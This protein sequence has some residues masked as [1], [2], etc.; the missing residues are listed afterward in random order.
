M[1]NLSKII[2]AGAEVAAWAVPEVS[3]AQEQ[4]SNPH[5]GPDIS[6]ELAAE[7]AALKQQ[8]YQEG[9][10]QGRQAGLAQAQA[11]IDAQ[12]QRFVAILDALS[13][14]LD[15][16][17][18]RVEQELLTL[19][20]SIAR[21]IVRREI[22][23][24]PAQVVGVVKEALSIL[25]SG[26]QNIEVHLHPEDARLVSDIMLANVDER[27]WKVIEDPVMG[28]GGC[29]VDTDSSTVDASI[30]SR[31]AAIAARLMGGERTD[32]ER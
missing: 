23:T 15:H 21:Q 6:A 3:G 4:H 29:R 26:V 24:E 9:L 22:K 16:M 10:E 17:E 8:A 18:E 7:M 1:K 28:Q 5:K 20:V 27:K 12:Q 31:I 32:D 11:A 30:D 19:S 2:S 25:P 14:P 13:R